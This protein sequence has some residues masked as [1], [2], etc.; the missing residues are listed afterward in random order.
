MIVRNCDFCGRKYTAK[1][2]RSRFCCDK[3][4]VYAN[5]GRKSWRIASESAPT[6]SAPLSR[7]SITA[8]EVADAVVQLK[9]AAATL[10]AA[11]LRGPMATRELC[12]RLSAAVLASVR[13][14]GL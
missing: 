10:D 12:R 7:P 5:M 4:R 8:D 11:A 9:G 13:E 6:P 2:K 1:T 3:C 14:S